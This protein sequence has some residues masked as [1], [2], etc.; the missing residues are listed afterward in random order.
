MQLLKLESYIPFISK[1][2]RNRSWVST[3]SS[4]GLNHHAIRAKLSRTYHTKP[5]IKVVSK[6]FKRKERNCTFE[7][8][9]LRCSATKKTLG[10][11]LFRAT[12]PSFLAGQLMS[13]LESPAALSQRYRNLQH[14]VNI[15][16]TFQNDNNIVCG[17]PV[18]SQ[19]CK[20]IGQSP[21]RVC[22]ISVNP[23]VLATV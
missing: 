21:L 17:N 22:C 10:L 11:V 9:S 12:C 18:S 7:N 20:K 15:T 2:C 14:S 16:E 23:Q 3:L 8:L 4:I 6:S 13:S 19:D 5:L 1:I